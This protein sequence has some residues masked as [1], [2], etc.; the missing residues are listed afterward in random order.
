MKSLTTSSHRAPFAPL[1]DNF[2]F[3]DACRARF[4]LARNRSL[5]EEPPSHRAGGF[6]P[7]PPSWTYASRHTIGHPADAPNSTHWGQGFDTSPDRKSSGCI[8]PYPIHSH[9]SIDIGVFRTPHVVQEVSDTEFRLYTTE[10]LSA[11]SLIEETTILSMRNPF[12]A[13]YATFFIR[14][15]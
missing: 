3:T 2:C 15:G 4:R 5:E 9:P 10:N 6:T 1:G 8:Q 7:F 13:Q 12:S 14:Y 11:A